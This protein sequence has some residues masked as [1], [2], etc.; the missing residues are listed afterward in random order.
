MVCTAFSIAA[1]QAQCPTRIED[2]VGDGTR[3]LFTL[4]NAAQCVHFPQFAKDSIQGKRYDVVFCNTF[5]G[6]TT[7]EIVFPGLASTVPVTLAKEPIVAVKFG[8]YAC[9]YDNTGTTK[10]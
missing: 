1:A 7:A 8:A 9:Q 2:V 6:V 3:Y 4:A 5:A 10:N